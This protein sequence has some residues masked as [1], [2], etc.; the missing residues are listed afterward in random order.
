MMINEKA[1]NNF[2]RTLRHNDKIVSS[3]HKEL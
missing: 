1:G 2:R 3:F